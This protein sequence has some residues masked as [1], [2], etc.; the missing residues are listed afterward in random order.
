MCVALGVACAVSAA[1]PSADVSARD[2]SLRSVLSRT[3]GR[4]AV[5]A[6][7]NRE[8]VASDGRNANAFTPLH[9]ASI[10]KTLTAVAVLRLAERGDVKLSDPI[11]RYIPD[12]FPEGANTVLGE[13]PVSAFLNHVTGSQSNNLRAVSSGIAHYR[14]Y[15]KLAATLDTSSA[16]Q[17]KYSNDNYVLLTVLVEEVTKRDFAFAARQLVWQPLGVW[18]GYLDTWT[19]ATRVLGGA[20]A[21]VTSAFNVALLMDALEPATPGDKLLGDQWMT[22][23][24]RE[25]PVAHYRNGLRYRN[26]YWGHTGSLARVRSAAIAGNNGVSY[27]VLS[28]GATP[29]SSDK[30]FDALISLDQRQ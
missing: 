18:G 1:S 23:L 15:A 14:G 16:G 7:R 11:S 29:E 9:L 12:Y 13:Q 4:T 5:V 21:W 22:F 20:G 6:V 24:H 25:N 3:S 30:L 27:A 26:G 28:E 8:I 2:W 17:Y 10:S 19:H